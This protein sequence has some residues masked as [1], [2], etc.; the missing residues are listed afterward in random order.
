MAQLPYYFWLDPDGVAHD[1]GDGMDSHDDWAAKYLDNVDGHLYGKEYGDSGRELYNRQWLRGVHEKNWQAREV[2]VNGYYAPNS[3]Q[4]AVLEAEGIE[5]GW[6]VRFLLKYGLGRERSTMIY[7]PPFVESR[8]R[9]ML[10]GMIGYEFP[11]EPDDGWLDPEGNFQSNGGD[12]HADTACEIMDDWGPNPVHKLMRRGWVRIVTCYPTPTE[13]PVI[14]V[15]CVK[16]PSSA[17]RAFLERMGIHYNEDVEMVFQDNS[18]HT[19]F[20]HML[21][22]ESVEEGLPEPEGDYPEWFWLDPQGGVHAVDRY[23]SV[24]HDDWAAVHLGIV[25]SQ[26]EA[27]EKLKKLGWL[28]GLQDIEY[29]PYTVIVDGVKNPTKSQLA[30]LENMGM[31][32]NM[33]VVM[34]L[35]RGNKE[36]EYTLFR[37]P[38]KESQNVSE[39]PASLKQLVASF[40]PHIEARLYDYPDKGVTKL[41]HLVA[42]RDAPKGSGTAF[43]QALSKWADA[44]GRLLI[45]QTACHDP[46]RV[47]TSYKSTTSFSRLKNFYKRFG[48][49]P[50]YGK[51]TYRPDLDGSMHR[52]VKEL[53]GEACDHRCWIS[54]SGRE[55]DFSGGEEH[56]SAA[57]ELIDK[58]YPSWKWTNSARFKSGG[59][60]FAGAA[61]LSRDWIRVVDPCNFEVNDLRGRNR[62][63]VE[64]Q[65]Y[66]LSP[67]DIVTI[68]VAHPKIYLQRVTVEAARERLGLLG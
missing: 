40:N 47:P 42:Q 22:P 39:L 18:R 24:L 16:K 6:P 9:R 53:L 27:A 62:E 49:V 63:F 52:P 64:D 3:K 50:N 33:K 35:S 19:L 34:L 25:T 12:S 55:Y 17:Q 29:E 58:L 11:S 57:S 5:R 7:T 38:V 31:T 48:F 51:R 2:I 67:D 30:S 14:F 60:Y 21:E 23:N 15:E 4:L 46:L 44:N 54:P 65:L 59:A 37:P 45:L 43:M 68:D 56:D 1:I 28:R 61:L 10:E 32:L 36:D 41:D 66:S 20:T 26:G 13:L 8:A